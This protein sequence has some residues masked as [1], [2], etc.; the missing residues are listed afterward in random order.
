MDDP[1]AFACTLGP[2]DLPPWADLAVRLNLGDDFDSFAGPAPAGEPA[3][4]PRRRPADRPEPAP[5]AAGA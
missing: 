2:M 1:A 3:D 5:V 4:R